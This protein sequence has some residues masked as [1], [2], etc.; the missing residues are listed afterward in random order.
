MSAEVTA[1]QEQTR[2]SSLPPLELV[3]GAGWLVPGP[4]AVVIGSGW[5]A[6]GCAG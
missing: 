2:S 3:V 4:E 1:D 5:L 6:R